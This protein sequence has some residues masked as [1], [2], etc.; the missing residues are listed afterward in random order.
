MESQKPEHSDGSRPASPSDNDLERVLNLARQGN[1]DAQHR[2]GGIYIEGKGVPKNEEEAAYWFRKAA[3]QGLASAQ[4]DLGNRY[5]YGS[6]VSQDCTQA[7]MWYRKAA[8]QGS[9]DGQFNLGWLFSE[10]PEDARDIGEALKWC[11]KAAQQGDAQAQYNLGVIYH[12]GD[13]VTPNYAEALKWYLKAA[14]QGELLAQNNIGLMYEYGQGVISDYEEARKWYEKAAEKGYVPAQVKLGR[15]YWL[16]RGTAQ[17]ED[18]ALKWYRLAAEN[19][20]EGAETAISRIEAKN[21][22][23]Y[24]RNGK[25]AYYD[26]VRGILILKTP[27]ETVRQEFLYMLQIKYQVPSDA[28]ELEYPLIKYTGKSRKRADIVIFSDQKP[29]M[30]IEC[31][32][33]NT[34]LLDNVFEQCRDY[35]DHL[36]CKMLAITNGPD[37]KSFHNVN[38]DWQEIKPFPSFDEMVQPHTIKHMSK[39]VR[40]INPLTY[41]QVRDTRFLKNFSNKLWEDYG[42]PILGEDTPEN[43]WPHIANLFN[44]IFT[45]K[46]IRSQL[47]YKYHDIDIAQFLGYKYTTY[48]NASGGQFPG[49]YASFRIVDSDGNDQIY[50]IGFFGSAHTENDPR[51]G[52]RKGTS[53]IHV[54]I[55]NFDMSPHPSIILAFDIC[56]KVSGNYFRVDHDGRITVGKLGAA[57]PAL[58]MDCVKKHASYLIGKNGLVN[59]GEFQTNKLL[60]FDDVKEFLFRLMKYAEVRDKFRME[61]KAAKKK[62][63]ALSS[64]PELT[65]P[66]PEIKASPGKSPLDSL[67]PTHKKWGIT[68][69]PDGSAKLNSSARMLLNPDELKKVKAVIAAHN[70]GRKK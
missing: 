46:N 38:G 55:D 25:T 69:N 68:M 28:I 61:Y 67:S 31:K 4:V 23:E 65:E 54:A 35:A 36:E 49:L 41:D 60:G 59:L 13:G 42:F 64:A 9:V 12:N 7:A 63:T 37:T 50:R 20:A 11:R 52:N 47:P 2:L 45:S 5:L 1:A 62:G 17:D 24:S 16:G 30:V 10:G 32:D 6:G 44:A 40:L 33:A 27:E 70:A 43:L 58:L 48:G 34:P 19:G 66:K 22:K 56:M 8:E 3:E 15:M 51:F 39:E 21:L 26:S 14:E 18:E 53:G 57:K 29:I